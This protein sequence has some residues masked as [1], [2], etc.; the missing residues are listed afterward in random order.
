MVLLQ[1]LQFYAG[2]ER[3]DPTVCDTERWSKASAA[4]LQRSQSE[5][6][7]AIQMLSGNLQLPCIL[8]HKS[9]GANL[10]PTE[11][12]YPGGRE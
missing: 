1:G 5:R 9:K 11:R 3:Y 7:K 2:I 4:T 8:Q 6:A 12:Q 10:R